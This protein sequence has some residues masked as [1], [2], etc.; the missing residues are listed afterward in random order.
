MNFV[1]FADKQRERWRRTTLCCTYAIE[2]ALFRYVIMKSPINA[3]FFAHKLAVILNLIVCTYAALYLLG[4]N[5]QLGHNR[6]IS[7]LFQFVIS[8]HQFMR[9]YIAEI[10]KSRVGI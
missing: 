5:V 10:P 7:H 4:Q 9:C 1:T 2:V 6:F 3:E 8:C